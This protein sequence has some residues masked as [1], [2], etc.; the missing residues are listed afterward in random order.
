MELNLKTYKKYFSSKYLELKY[1]FYCETNY[2]SER[3]DSDLHNNI[4]IPLIKDYRRDLPEKYTHIRI[5][6]V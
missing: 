2:K 3:I 1:L 6:I 5:T 4:N